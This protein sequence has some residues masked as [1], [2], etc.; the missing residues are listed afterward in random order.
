MNHP[1][2]DEQLQMVLKNLLSKF[3]KHM[4]FQYFPSFKALIATGLWWKT[5]LTEESSKRKRQ[6]LLLLQCTTKASTTTILSL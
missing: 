4:G 6:H 2:E 5:Q 3:K 1:S